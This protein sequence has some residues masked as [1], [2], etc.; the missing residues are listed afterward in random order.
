MINYRETGRSTIKLIEPSFSELYDR[1]VRRDETLTFQRAVDRETDSRVFSLLALL[2]AL[3][4][5]LPVTIGDIRTEVS[6]TERQTTLGNLRRKSRMAFEE[7]GTNILYL[8]F[9]FLE[10]KEGKNA[11]AARLKSPL[12]LVPVTLNIE[13]LNSPFTLKRREDDIVTNPTLTYYLRTEYG[14]ELPQFDPEKSTPDEY[15]ASV[16]EIADQMGWRVLRESWLGL[17]SFLKISM[18]NDLIR[19]EERIRANPVIRAMAGDRSALP[20]VFADA[21]PQ[22]PDS[23]R[24]VDCYSVMSADSS[25]QEA[26]R[27][28]K[29]NVSFVMQ[30]PPGTGKS[31]TIANIIA[32]ALAAGKKVL[33]VSE[34][35]A[36]LQVVYRRLQEAHL[37]EFC[38]PLHS[39]KA[40]KKEII[41]QIGANLSLKQPRVKDA[42]I[43]KLEDLF[44]TREELND[45]ARQLHA[46]RSALRWSCYEVYCKLEEVGDA[47]AIEFQLPAPLQ[48]SQEQLQGA[49]KTLRT[50][51]LALSRLDPGPQGNPWEGIARLSV[52]CDQKQQ[53]AARLTAVKDAL[54]EQTAL[55]GAI[56]GAG[57]APDGITVAGS[58]DMYRKLLQI[59]DLPKVPHVWLEDFDFA[60]ASA[61][62]SAARADAA[63]MRGLREAIAA[64]FRDSIFSCRY[65]DWKDLLIAETE[66]CMRLPLYADKSADF[67]ILNADGLRLHFM[68]LKS[69]LTEMRDLLGK[70]NAHLGS[71]FDERKT[72][73][74]AIEELVEIFEKGLV[75]QKNWFTADFD[76]ILGLAR[77][78]REASAQ[79]R[80]IREKLLAHWEPEVLELDY[81]PML[82]RYKTAYTSLFKYFNGQ[83]GRDRMQIKALSRTVMA[84]LPDETAIELLLQLKSYHENIA[85]LTEN[86]DAL[87]QALGGDY[88][89]QNTD[90]NALFAALDAFDRWRALPRCNTYKTLTELLC[91]RSDRE[92]K[93]LLPLFAAFVAKARDARAEISALAIRTD[94][95]AAD[96]EID[97]LLPTLDA[98]LS[99]LDAVRRKAGDLQAHFVQADTTVDAAF[100][101]IEKIN[102]Y[103]RLRDA[104][105]D[106]AGLYEATFGKLYTE[107]GSDWD[108]ILALLQEVSALKDTAYFDAAAFLLEA[109]ASEK[110]RVKN[111]VLAAMEKDLT[112]NEAFQWLSSRFTEGTPLT[113]MPVSALAD[114]LNGCLCSLSQMEA[115]IDYLEAKG[116]C[117]Q[118][119]L[120]ELIGRYECAG[121]QGDLEAIFLKGFYLQWLDAVYGESDVLRQFRRRLQDERVDAFARLDTR[122]FDIAQMRIR[123]K[124]IAELPS[125]HHL[126]SAT[127][128][129]SI[130][131]K[132]L[133]KKRNVMPLRKLFRQIPNLLLRLKPCLLMSPLSVSYFLEAEAYH[134]D[135]VIFDEASQIFPEDAVGAI[136]RGAQVIIAGDSKQMP[137]TDFFSVTT[138]NS[139]GD[140]DSADEEEYG[141]VV[142]DSILEEAASTLPNCTLLWH[143]RS[144][145]ESLIAFSNCA[146]YKNSLITFPSSVSAAEDT[147]VEYIYLADGCYDRGR[148]KNNIREA[149]EC[150]RLVAEHIEK[151][152]DRSLGVI[153]FS[154]SQQNTIEDA[155]TDFR[156]RNPQYEWFFDETREEPFFVKNLENVQG[157]ERDT[158]LFSICYGKDQNGVMYMNFGPVGH[159]GGERRLNV[160]ITRAK[161]NIKLIGSI[162]PSDIDP[163]RAKSEGARLLRA[164]IE[165]ARK[166]TSVLGLRESGDPAEREDAFCT[167]VADFLTA[168]GYAVE[169][170][171]GCSDYRI[172]L[173]VRKPGVEGEYLAGIECDGFSYRSAKTAR[174]RD[175]LRRSVL[176]KMGWR[177]YRVWSTAWVRNPEEEQNALLSFLQ[178]LQTGA[179]PL[180][181]AAAGGEKIS[182][183]ELVEYVGTEQATDAENPYGFPYYREADALQIEAVIAQSPGLTGTAASVLAI[184]AA[185]QPIHF[186]LLC[187]RLCSFQNC[188]ATE[189][190]K[191]CVEALLGQE[192]R[193]LTVADDERFF[194][195]LPRTAVVAR[196]P[197]PSQTPRPI[198]YICGEEIETALLTILRRSVGISPEAL[199]KE[200]ACAFGFTRQGARIKARIEEAIQRLQ[201]VNKIH[202]ADGKVQRTGE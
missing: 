131:K 61:L 120:G 5:P 118:C 22:D 13:A 48:L 19:N 72:D 42:E 95:D 14:I 93:E 143:Y 45:Y 85:R 146:F 160:A 157:D 195:L 18:Y 114:K 81:A 175:H 106:R 155:I 44:I 87:R 156:E 122:Q 111:A 164:Y 52:G 181:P 4:S 197:A 177:M 162:L 109:D 70:I 129:V 185:E 90:W 86:A 9:G 108:R 74:R 166:G 69:A 142:S 20:P 7:Q 94:P 184:I 65:N 41:E 178:S 83:Y 80:A 150:V 112:Q 58:T 124:L 103:T 123:E 137:P 11:S 98:Y 183:G 56:F 180:P 132:E 97:A 46:V 190:T 49:L 116:A 105:A 99:S 77:R 51:A 25:Q 153:A 66:K 149:E 201:I 34:K 91:E 63:N 12:I 23:I 115:W 113:E 88:R 202:I 170:R 78:A 168:H 141:D 15:M 154:E 159:A 24:P 194:R 55:F 62:A 43:A 1:L 189:K 192:L 32:E 76:G 127:D 82:L 161:R 96:P 187:K 2:E 193:D 176:Q 169:R 27:Y 102:A 179:D 54:S 30:G 37:G 117:A 53:M 50:Y 107:S 39:Y 196:I 38:L 134:F 84:K 89:G 71:G 200:C 60:Q 75:F 125:D 79:V 33:F 28:A 29:E 182:A 104:F 6:I 186:D 173:A 16:E 151:H 21:A 198:E 191:N 121:A 136:F 126:L 135:L 145:H 35:M 31:Q 147:G 128:E 133:G 57:R 3:S 110:Q 17:L 68:R 158:I 152:P 174:D 148:R 36:A 100:A 163:A 101:G 64:V 47:P 199:V 139:G 40:N 8:S 171:V 165:Y 140:Y 172:D 144:K 10:R 130:L 59:C 138:G 92:T 67:F 188:K 26:V 73:R 119:G 167:L